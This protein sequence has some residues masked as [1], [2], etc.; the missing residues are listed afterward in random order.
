[1][2]TYTY[3]SEEPCDQC[4][5]VQEI[6]QRMSDA[7]LS[8]CE[9]CGKCLKRVVSLPMPAMVNKSGLSD[10][11]IEKA[12]FTKYVRTGDGKYEKT[13]GSDIAPAKLDRD[14]MPD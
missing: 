7:P 6:M 14:S 5:G 4:G 1:M 3:R 12:G 10:S 2:P 8:A 11:R 9:E 13:V